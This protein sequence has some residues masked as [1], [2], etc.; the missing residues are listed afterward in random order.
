MTWANALIMLNVTRTHTS[1]SGTFGVLSDDDGTQ[2]CVTV[3]LPWLNNEHDKSCIPEGTYPVTHYASPTKGTV[4]LL[5]N[6]PDRDM[7]EIHAGNTIH[8]VLG[9]IAV[10]DSLGTVSGLPAVMNSRHTLT[11]LL[12]TLPDSFD[13]TIKNAWN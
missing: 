1:P 2:Y 7:I 3:E 13:L 12:L 5:H 11:K 4:F 9:C 8:D 6:V 10:G